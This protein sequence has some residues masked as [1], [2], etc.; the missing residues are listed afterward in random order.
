MAYTVEAINPQTSESFGLTIAGDDGNH[1]PT[2]SCNPNQNTDLVW[3][4]CPY[5]LAGG[6]QL[7][8]CA[9]SEEHLQFK[10]VGGRRVIAQCLNPPGSL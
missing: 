4:L 6:G 7:C 1:R 10:T 3:G 2:A 9:R 5:F 8:G